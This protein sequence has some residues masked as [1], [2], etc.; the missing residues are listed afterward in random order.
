MIKD[1]CFEIIE[2]C[3]NQCRFCSSNSC[4]SKNKIIDI[5]TFQR[6]IDYFMENGGIE[7]LSL[8]GGE[9]L[10][11][12]NLLEMVNYA[13]SHGIKVVIFTSGVIKAQK[14][15]PDALAILTKEMNSKI[16]EVIAKEPW[17]T[18]LVAKIKN[19]YQNYINPIGYTNIPKKKL[20]LLKSLKLDKIVFD[21]QAH[22]A[23]TDNYLMGRSEQARQAALNSLI[24]AAT[25]NLNI[26]IHFVPMKQNYQEIIDIL[27]MLTIAD[28]KSISILN[29]I[30][31]G[32]GKNN[33]KQ[34]QLSEEELNHFFAILN[35]AKK[36]YPGNIRIGIPL[37]DNPTH[38][39]N[40]GLGK[41]NI[42]FDGTVLPCPAFKKLSPEE[43][44]KYNI[45]LF[46]IYDD[47]EKIKI[48]GIGTRTEPLCQKVYSKVRK[49]LN[50]S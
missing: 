20:M 1:L 6:V 25:C 21:Y 27:E 41:L 30:P 4:I 33:A 45:E 39:C 26:D 47:L 16:N 17:N 32:R 28:V 10:L 14:P 13:K 7:K 43:C 37:Q 34:L 42:K 31:Q 22:E 23:N 35:E 48:K 36:H 40:A 15:T 12:P 11:H 19:H 49:Q 5:S 50:D 3:P 38:K 9:P 24:L 2:A 18:N 44:Q 46:N 8:S 29:F